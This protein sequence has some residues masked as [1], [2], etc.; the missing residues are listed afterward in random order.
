MRF[1]M[2]EKPIDTQHQKVCFGRYFSAW[3]L[4]VVAL[5]L[6]SC[7]STYE[8][9]VTYHVEF[10]ADG[11]NYNVTTRYPWYYVQMFA[12]DHQWADY[13]RARIQ[14][15][16]KDGSEYFVTAGEY[17][18]YE[19]GRTNVQPTIFVRIAPNLA[20][21]FD[22]NHSHSSHHTIHI[23][24]AYVDIRNEGNVPYDVAEK[25][26]EKYIASQKY[27]HIYH[28]VGAKFTPF[29]SVKDAQHDFYSGSMP[30]NSTLP[31]YKDAKF[32]FHPLDATIANS[33]VDITYDGQ[34]FHPVFPSAGLTPTWVEDPH[35]TASGDYTS[36]TPSDIAIKFNH[37]SLVISPTIRR[38]FYLDPR[39]HKVIIFY[40]DD[41]QLLF[42]TNDPL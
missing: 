37:E 26:N 1:L 41:A 38:T 33:D 40:D 16:L 32:S 13:N 14:G 3:M 5:S 15:A 2:K 42:K 25:I 34:F 36:G 27:I 12:V 23:I 20:E 28:S 6:T 22:A 35:I 9:I 18:Y 31:S 10:T 19:S 24:K 39:T 17:Y 4:M 29:D 8:K 21:S 7:T 11:I 30:E